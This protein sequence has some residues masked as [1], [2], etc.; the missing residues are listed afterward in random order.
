MYFLHSD[1]GAT[2]CIICPEGSMCPDPSQDPVAC[3]EG[4]IASVGSDNCSRC[5]YDQISNALNTDCLPCPAGQD[6]TDPTLD[7]SDCADGEYALLGDGACQACP[8]GKRCPTTSTVEDCPPG[9]FGCIC[10][11]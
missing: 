2:Q 6:C 11:Y 3:N 9:K 7:P 8:A 10:I 1:E 4:Y 5:S